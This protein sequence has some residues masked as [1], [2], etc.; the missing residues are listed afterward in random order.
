MYFGVELFDDRFGYM[1][2][3]LLIPINPKITGNGFLKALIPFEYLLRAGDAPHGE[4]S[5]M[6]GCPASRRKGQPFPGGKVAGARSQEGDVGR[7]GDG[8]GVCRLACI[9]S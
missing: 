7:S 4:E 5:R 2:E 1:F 9:Q 8:N 3:V 6:G